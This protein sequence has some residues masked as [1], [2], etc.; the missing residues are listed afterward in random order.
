MSDPS[1]TYRQAT[2]FDSAPC[3]S[4]PASADGPTR[5]DSPDGQTN[6]QYGPEAVPV[7]PSARRGSG[8]G[9][10]TKDT[11]GRCSFGS[12]ATAGLQR[13]LGN[14][15][16]LTT[17]TDGSPEYEMTWRKRAMQSGPPICRLAARARRISGNGCSGWPTVSTED[18]KSDGP[19]AM[20]KIY[21]AIDE[22]TA[23]PTTCQRLRN[24]AQLAGW[25]TPM[26][27]NPGTEEY[28][29][30]GNTD[31][32]R[33]TVELIAGWAT[34]TSRDS[35]DGACQDANVLIN[36]LLGRQAAKLTSGPPTTSSPAE[37]G[38]RGV[39]N[40]D[41]SRWLQGYPA[42]WGCCGATAIASCRK[43][44]RSSSARTSTL[45]PKRKDKRDD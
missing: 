19:N 29:P 1:A 37:T 45:K 32:S 20:A 4:S 11:S 8:K 2:L 13:A 15:L 12:S 25:P 21:A 28:N 7:S 23:I 38:V 16:L 43:S 41:H 14:R 42:A 18:Y 40:P 6:G 33:K 3:I 10:R 31:S 24:F 36:G 17:D 27:G 39:L 35:K 30:A 22:G 9:K 5:C 44:R 34:P 26:A